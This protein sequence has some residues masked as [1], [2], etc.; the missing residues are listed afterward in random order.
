MVKKVEIDKPA[1]FMQLAKEREGYYLY[2]DHPSDGVDY[3]SDPGLEDLGWNACAFPFLD[4]RIISEFI[5]QN[6]EGT[7]TFNETM[8]FHGFVEVDD[9][10]D[11]REKV[12]AFCCKKIGENKLE[13]YDDEQLESLEFF[14]ISL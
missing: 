4:Y 11:V 12:K 10:E 6:C 13:D 3:F 1:D 5:E 14:G 2:Y 8:G 9:I 7:I